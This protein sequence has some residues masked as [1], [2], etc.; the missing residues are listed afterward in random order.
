VT[1]PRRRDQPDQP[2]G[3]GDAGAFLAQASDTDLLRFLRRLPMV[4]GSEDGT[5]TISD[6]IF[7]MKLWPFV[8]DAWAQVDGQP[9]IP[10]RLMQIAG[11]YKRAEAQLER[12]TG[13]RRR[14]PRVIDLPSFIKIYT[15][16]G[17]P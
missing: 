4:A 15:G 13:E 12:E 2:E 1:M 7:E 9:G 11:V 6:L 16:E 3:I 8:K 10:G 14:A 5:I 17:L